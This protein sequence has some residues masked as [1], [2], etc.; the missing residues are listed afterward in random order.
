M[1]DRLAWLRVRDRS[2]FIRLTGVLFLVYLATG[3]WAPL[4]AVYVG[5]LGAGTGQIGL[6]FAAYQASSLA[7]QYWWG[8]FSDRMGRRKPLLL[9][10]TAGLSVAYLGIA[11]SSHYSWLFAVRALEGVALAAYS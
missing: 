8:R 3:L 11:S 6:L 4:L 10:G 9:L 7:S 2:A 5:T 1:I